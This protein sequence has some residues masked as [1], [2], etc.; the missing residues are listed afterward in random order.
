MPA[1]KITF[2]ESL[3]RWNEDSWN[4]RGLNG[5]IRG[6]NLSRAIFADATGIFA[7]AFCPALFSRTQQAVSRMHSAPG[8]FRGCNEQ[9]RGSHFASEDFRGCFVAFRVRF[10]L[11][12]GRNVT[13]RVRF[14]RSRACFPVGQTPEATRPNQIKAPA[15]IGLALIIFL[16]S[17]GSSAHRP[18]SSQSGR[19]PGVFLC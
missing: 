3:C 2:G 12:R 17:A 7:D 15:V 5:W 13:F 11:F 16:I 10:F 1:A 8:D 4:F 19:R 9:F 18:P 14:A 6:C